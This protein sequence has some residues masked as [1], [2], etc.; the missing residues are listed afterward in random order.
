M[1]IIVH[2]GNGGAQELLVNYLRKFKDDDE[3][4][5]W[6]YVVEG[7]RKSKYNEIIQKEKLNVKYLNAPSEANAKTKVGWALRKFVGSF[8]IGKAIIDF[9]PDII[10]THITQIYE[11]ALLPLIFLKSGIIFHT[12]HSNPNTYRGF[13]LLLA[14]AAFNLKKIIPVCINKKQMYN[15]KEHYNFKDAKLLYNSIDIHEIRKNMIVKEVARK[16]YN[17][18]K[19]AFVIGAVGRI[20]PVKNYSLLIDIFVEVCK[21]KENAVLLIIGNGDKKDI[22]KKVKLSDLEDKVF[23]MGEVENP[24]HLY[25]AMDVYVNTS[26][27]E[28]CS[29]TTLEAQAVGIN[30]VISAEVPDETIFTNHVCKISLSTSVTEWANQICFFQNNTI[31]FIKEESYT[32]EHNMRILKDMY[33]KEY[34]RKKVNARSCKYKSFVN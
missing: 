15:A 25:C 31:P 26:I 2:L 6:V 20:S 24:T 29:L 13:D 9:R 19:N 22:L 4:E 5:Y 12:L 7:P 14:K 34:C 18:D 11:C 30:C 33:K 17:I 3:F 27:R 16:K 32:I 21:Q 10:H 1:N 23:F 8:Y 28:S